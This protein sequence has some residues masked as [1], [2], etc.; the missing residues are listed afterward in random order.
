M[1][2]DG[3]GSGRVL[4]DT[5]T[6]GTGSSGI[7]K[8]TDG[9]GFRWISLLPSPQDSHEFRSS[10]SP[11]FW[12][13][14]HRQYCTTM[15][16]KTTTHR[17]GI[18]LGGPT[19]LLRSRNELDFRPAHKV[20]WQWIRKVYESPPFRHASCGQPHINCRVEKNSSL[21]VGLGLWLCWLPNPQL[22]CGKPRRMFNPCGVLHSATHRAGQQMRLPHS[23]IKLLE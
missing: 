15:R 6:D 20:E 21:S 4:K 11:Y 23:T 19:I 5:D 16:L 14:S 1:G 9:A 17:R 22:N 18:L 12:T 3:S 7:L 2:W 10:S 13:S 8:D